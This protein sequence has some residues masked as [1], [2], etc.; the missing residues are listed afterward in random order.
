MKYEE[1]KTGRR[2]WIYARKNGACPARVAVQTEKLLKQ[3]E[4]REW[5]VVGMS[6]DRCAG[7]CLRRPGIQEALH[8]VR[9]GLA[10]TVLVESLD[11]I[12]SNRSVCRRF[13]EL[14]QDHG[15]ILAAAGADLRYEIWLS[16]LEAALL[17]R[18]AR[19]HCGVPW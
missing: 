16:G 13:L 18:A 8:A 5:T 6:Q 3:A 7:D 9:S 1:D 15:A 10:N 2:V 14:L 4:E 17:A 12:G 19:R 11:R